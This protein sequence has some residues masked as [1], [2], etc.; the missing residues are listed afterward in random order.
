MKS[1]GKLWSSKVVPSEARLELTRIIRDRCQVVHGDEDGGIAL[2]RENEF[3]N[4]ANQVLGKPIHL[5]VVTGVNTIRLS[6]PGTTGS[7]N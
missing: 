2:L 4:I 7:V 6:T 1:S 3:I 5:E